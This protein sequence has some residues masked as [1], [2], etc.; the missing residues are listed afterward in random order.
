[1]RALACAG[2]ADMISRL[3]RGQAFRF[4]KGSPRV[5]AFR[6]AAPPFL[7][8]AAAWSLLALVIV[9]VRL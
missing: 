3:W 5:C 6:A 9:G 8:L 1:M 4:T 7:T 2:L